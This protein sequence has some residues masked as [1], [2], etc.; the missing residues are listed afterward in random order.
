[1]LRLKASSVQLLCV[2]VDGYEVL[3]RGGGGHQDCMLLVP[4]Q[5]GLA[6]HF[7][8]NVSAH[9]QLLR[10]GNWSKRCLSTRI[11]LTTALAPERHTSDPHA[12]KLRGSYVS[13]TGA[14]S[15]RTWT[16]P[17]DPSSVHSN[18]QPRGSRVLDFAQA[19]GWLA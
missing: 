16:R 6:E 15:R 11:Y 17:P 19:S 8:C 18:G 3:G 10:T 5:D 12:R 4:A 7:F 9:R 2:G 13:G 14:V 1:M